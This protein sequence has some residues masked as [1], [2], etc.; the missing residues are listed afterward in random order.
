MM[1][2]MSNEQIF[3]RLARLGVTP[4]QAAEGVRRASADDD[5][6]VHLYAV[7][8]CDLCVQGEGGECHTPGCA[9]WINRAPIF[10][11]LGNPMCRR[12][13]EYESDKNLQDERP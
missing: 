3:E 11:L 1:E 4:D 6:E 13:E 5:P 9:L 8:L 10:S 12:I 2:R 7:Y